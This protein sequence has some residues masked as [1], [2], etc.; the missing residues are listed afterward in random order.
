MKIK[1]I[2]WKWKSIASENK[3]RKLEKV[4]T[5]LQCTQSYNVKEVVRTKEKLTSGSSNVRESDKYTTSPVKLKLGSKKLE[6]GGG[7]KI[8]TKQNLFKH[9]IW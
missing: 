1:F 5:K 7:T 9:C 8:K 2:F 4:K 3:S 6:K